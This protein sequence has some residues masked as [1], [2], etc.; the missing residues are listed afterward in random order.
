MPDPFTASVQIAV[1]MTC[2]G[3]EKTVRSALK[4]VEG[5]ENLDVNLKEQII[6][7]KGTAQP[8]EIV[9][10]LREA[11]KTAIVRGAGNVF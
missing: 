5:I 1:D 4:N 11:G 9:S 10:K 8:S 7:V 2:N 6:V 3:C